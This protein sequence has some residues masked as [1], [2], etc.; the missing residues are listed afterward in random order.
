MATK[1]YGNFEWDEAKAAANV[2]KH[3][4]T[5]E[6]GTTAWKDEHRLVDVD[7]QGHDDRFILIGMSNK[8]RILYVVHAEKIDKRHTRIISVRL[9]TKREKL[10]Y[11][12]PL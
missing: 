6:E 1:R 10:E 4:V 5:F 7:P 3:G 8:V 9:A 12:G 11:T 2:R